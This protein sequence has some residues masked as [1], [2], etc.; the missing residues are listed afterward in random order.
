MTHD[1]RDDRGDPFTDRNEH[2][3]WELFMAG[4]A[5]IFVWLSFANDDGGLGTAGTVLEIAFIAFFFGEFLVRLW[6]SEDRSACAI[7]HWVDVV[8]LVP[9]MPGLRFLRM[10]RLLRLFR[11]AGGLHRASGRVRRLQR[12]QTLVNL[13]IAWIVVMAI[14]G[15][16]FWAAESE[17]NRNVNDPLDALWWTVTT[18][19]GGQSEI[20]PATGEGRMAAAI[21]LLGGVA[22]FAAITASVFRILGADGDDRLT[23]EDHLGQ[24]VASLVARHTNSEITEDEFDFQMSS[25]TAEARRRGSRRGRRLRE[26]VHYGGGGS[27][28]TFQVEAEARIPVKT[29]LISGSTPAVMNVAALTLL[30]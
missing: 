12:I 29:P 8:A 30:R 5:V 6:A 23:A 22:L 26:A 15:I 4:L 27:M 11:F 18:M 3:Q 14:G 17:V 28:S 1:G 25:I 7:D 2:V 13:V 19:T 24:Q 9:V 16:S 10:L 21:L 20:I